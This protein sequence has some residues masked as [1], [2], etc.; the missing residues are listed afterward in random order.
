MDKNWDI[1]G[2]ILF[3]LKLTRIQ[4]QLWH[5]K[6]ELDEHRRFLNKLKRAEAHI[7]AFYENYK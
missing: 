7:N 4:Q 3:E 2:E 1:L 5:A 6:A